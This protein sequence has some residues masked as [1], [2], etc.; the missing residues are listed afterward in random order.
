MMLP[1]DA[2]SVV[3]HPDN[4]QPVQVQQA[5]AN[6]SFGWCVP[7]RVLDQIPDRLIQPVGVAHDLDRIEM[8]GLDLM[9]GRYEPSAFDDALDEWDEG[10][11]L[12]LDGV[13]DVG[14][15]K[16]EQIVHEAAHPSNLDVRLR[17]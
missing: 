6:I 8:D 10:D 4:G 11:R 15:T 7:Q 3:L 1:R 2:G 9:A 17:G 16:Q 13:G 12:P 5:E 14:L